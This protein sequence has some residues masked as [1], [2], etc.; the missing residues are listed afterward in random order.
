MVTAGL[1]VGAP[2]MRNRTVSYCI[3]ALHD[4]TNLVECLYDDFTFRDGGTKRKT[5]ARKSCELH[6]SAII[7]TPQHYC[8]G[9]STVPVPDNKNVGNQLTSDFAMESGNQLIPVSDADDKL[10]PRS[11]TLRGITYSVRLAAMAVACRNA[12][13]MTTHAFWGQ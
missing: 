5:P 11:T 8:Q 2:G 9:L 4:A 10:G 12:I 6:H 13:I 3:G 1:G 7:K